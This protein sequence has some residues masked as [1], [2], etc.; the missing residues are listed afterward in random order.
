ML[1]MRDPSRGGGGSMRQT[2]KATC[3]NYAKDKFSC[4]TALTGFQDSV[5]LP[6]EQE[7]NPSGFHFLSFIRPK[8][9][10]PTQQRNKVYILML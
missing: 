6:S 2:L 3:L 5:M 10:H 9:L 8:G 7:R 1:Q 4:G